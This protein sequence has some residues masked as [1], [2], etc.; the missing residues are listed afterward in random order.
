[1]SKKTGPA[2]PLQE[3]GGPESVGF[4]ISPHPQQARRESPYQLVS[5]LSESQRQKVQILDINRRYRFWK[6]VPQITFIFSS[7]YVGVR[8]FRCIHGRGSWCC[9]CCFRWEFC[10]IRRAV[11][12]MAGNFRVLECP[13]LRNRFDPSGP[14]YKGD[15]PAKICEEVLQFSRLV[16]KANQTNPHFDSMI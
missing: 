6:D 7:N 11:Q 8:V 13:Y 4:A 1:M 9:T 12:E 2:G 16:A 15:D 10:E 14:Y 5:R 3:S